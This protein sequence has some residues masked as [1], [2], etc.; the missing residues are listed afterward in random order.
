ME[1]KGGKHL[2]QAGVACLKSVRPVSVEGGW[3]ELCRD[4]LQEAPQREAGQF[5]HDEQLR[6]TIT[7]R[8]RENRKP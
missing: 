7:N 6:S 3:T 8:E 4:P 5:V 2:K 1:K